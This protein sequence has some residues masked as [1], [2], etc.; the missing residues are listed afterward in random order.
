MTNPINIEQNEEIKYLKLACLTLSALEDVIAE[1][2][3]RIK[4]SRPGSSERLM[5]KI[6]LIDYKA[7]RKIIYTEIKGH[8]TS[9]FE[10]TPPTDEEVEEIKEITTTLDQMIADNKKTEGI[11]QLAT[12]LI[13][14]WKKTST[15]PIS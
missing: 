4:I 12:Q 8:L 9:D 15:T 13:A 1:L 5:L 6:N 7:K 3:G 2:S 10:I 14:L 11:V